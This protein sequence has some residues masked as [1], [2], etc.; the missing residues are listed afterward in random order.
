MKITFHKGFDLF[1][2]D[3]LCLLHVYCEYLEHLTQ[4][5]NKV[6]GTYHLRPVWSESSLC[7]EWVAKDP[8]FLHVDSEDSDQTGRM[9]RLIWVFAGRTAT[10]LVLSWGSSY[11]IKLLSFGI[12]Y[13]QLSVSDYLEHSLNLLEYRNTISV[14]NKTENN[15]WK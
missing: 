4:S 13:F 15:N 5:R 12:S 10:L 11:G 14:L 2:L 9:P 6:C 7:A 3:L 1:L 8:S